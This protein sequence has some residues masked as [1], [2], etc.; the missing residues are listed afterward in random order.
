MKKIL[1]LILFSTLNIDASDEK[2]D[3]DSSVFNNDSD[4]FKRTLNKVFF[5]GNLDAIN[6][7]YYLYKIDLFDEK[8][9]YADINQK[10]ML[11][12]PLVITTDTKNITRFISPPHR[13]EGILDDEDNW[14]RW[15]L[16]KLT[17]KTEASAS[18]DRKKKIIDPKNKSRDATELT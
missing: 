9:I 6:S 12:E 2:I 1:I 17:L 11:I 10:F 8:I 14:R 13:N 7:P 15:Y 4:M 3:Y 16:D 5:C 18:K